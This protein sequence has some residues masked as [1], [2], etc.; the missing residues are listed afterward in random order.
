MWVEEENRHILCVLGLAEACKPAVQ[1]C[2]ETVSG[3]IYEHL[4]IWVWL[5]GFN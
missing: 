1:L 5:V 3:G 2:G 4:T